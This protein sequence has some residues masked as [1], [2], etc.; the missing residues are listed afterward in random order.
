MANGGGGS[1][2]YGVDAPG[3]RVLELPMLSDVKQV[4]SVLRNALMMNIEP[5]LDFRV[6][7]IHEDDDE[8]RSSGVIEVAI[9]G[10]GVRALEFRRDGSREFWTRVDAS[11]RAMTAFEI[12]D[13]IRRAPG[14]PS[15][16]QE[17]LSSRLAALAVWEMRRLPVPEREH[18]REP[19]EA[20]FV[21]Y[22]DETE[23]LLRHSGEA[24][25]VT[26]ELGY[27]WELRFTDAIQF[28]GFLSNYRVA[29]DRFQA[30]LSPYIGDTEDGS[31][32]AALS[33]FERVLEF[34]HM[35]SYQGN[36]RLEG[37]EYVVALGARVMGYAL[38]YATRFG[39]TNAAR[40]AQ[41]TLTD[42]AAY[43]RGELFECFEWAL[44]FGGT[45]GERGA[46]MPPLLVTAEEDADGDLV[47]APLGGGAPRARRR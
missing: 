20:R 12:S 47:F 4:A 11:N 9:A 27:A 16:G 39:A 44:E 26:E 42:Q 24:A 37:A 28:G 14:H 33:I 43:Y 7:I 32:S 22:F 13:G 8:A 23:A 18:F 38:M 35:L 31:N 41:Q 40:E 21:R 10:G 25:P 15:R 2:V 30:L 19:N 36:R 45:G 6:H 17:Q 3:E 34:G 5:P 46:R 29:A 1:L